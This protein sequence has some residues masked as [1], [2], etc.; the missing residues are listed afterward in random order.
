MAQYIAALRE[1]LAGRQL[2]EEA[3]AHLQAAAGPSF[4]VWPA[5]DGEEAAAAAAETPAETAAE[6]GA[7]AG[8]AGGAVRTA[9]LLDLQRCPRMRLSPCYRI[10]CGCGRNE[11]LIRDSIAGT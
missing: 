9:L 1:L 11:K 5:A 2:S 4:G 6:H 8:N 10:P 3:A 7:A